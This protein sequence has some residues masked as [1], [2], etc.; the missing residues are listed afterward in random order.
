[1]KDTFSQWDLID[2]MKQ[3]NTFMSAKDICKETKTTMS[4]VNRKLSKLFPKRLEKKVIKINIGNRK[5]R[6]FKFKR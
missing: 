6:L 2:F 5:M 3:K 1:M 4:S